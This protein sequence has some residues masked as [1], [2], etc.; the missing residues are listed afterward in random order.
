MPTSDG[1]SPTGSSASRGRVIEVDGTDV[2]VLRVEEHPD[3]LYLGLVELLPAW[4][5]RGLGTD[6]LRWLLRRAHETGRPLSLAV[7]KTNPRAAALYE[8]EGLR[9]V[10]SEP[11]KLLM[12]SAP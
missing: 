10:G 11:A 8:R 9:V 1:C 7:L 6:I 12:R 2:G 5:N 4:Q 3:A